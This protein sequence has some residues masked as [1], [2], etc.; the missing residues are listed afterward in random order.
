[1]LEPVLRSENCGGGLTMSIASYAVELL[2]LTTDAVTEKGDP[3]VAEL[4]FTTTFCR[5]KAGV[6]ALGTMML[7]IA[8]LLDIVTV[9][10]P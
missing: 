1:M 7:T 3:G 5:D 9:W 10:L 2:V 8:A 6:G 4:A